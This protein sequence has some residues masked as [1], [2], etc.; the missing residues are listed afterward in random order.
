MQEPDFS[1]ICRFREKLKYLE[2]FRFK[3]FPAKSNDSIFLKMPKTFKNGHFSH[4][5]ANYAKPVFFLENPKTLLSYVYYNSTSCQ[6]LEKTNDGKYDNF[7]LL[8]TNY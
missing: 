2:F 8:T 1:R 5:Y 4:N 6:K 7:C 3:P